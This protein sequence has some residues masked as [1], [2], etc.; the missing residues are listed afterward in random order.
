M[1]LNTEMPDNNAGQTANKMAV[2]W[3]SVHTDSQAD[4]QSIVK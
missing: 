3:T 2:L 1:F 4:Q